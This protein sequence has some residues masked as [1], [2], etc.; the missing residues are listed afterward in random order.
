VPAKRKN[1]KSPKPAAP[2]PVK[3]AD[4]VAFY[5]LADHPD[6]RAGSG[7]DAEAALTAGELADAVL[8]RLA[9][10]QMS[11]AFEAVRKLMDQRPSEI[12]KRKKVR[13]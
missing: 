10:L 4:S 7:G 9:A 2:A 6:S 1:S 11:E 13:I 3:T 12:A 8:D 5:Y